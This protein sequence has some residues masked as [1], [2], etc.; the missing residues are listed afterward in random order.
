MSPCPSCRLPARPREENAS[1]P[2]CSERCKAVDL[3]RWFI[4]NY[5]VPGRP[6]PGAT[7]ESD[8]EGG[9]PGRRDSDRLD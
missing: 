6:D 7:R 3:S 1:F 2:F 9:E 8:G 4:G 5:R